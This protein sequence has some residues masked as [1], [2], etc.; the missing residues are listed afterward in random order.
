MTDLV[1]ISS[2]AITAYQRALATVSNNIANVAT[3]GYS[4]QDV[5]LIASKSVSLSGVSLGSGVSVQ[6]IQRQ[7]DAFIES[8]LRNSTSDLATQ[9]PMVDYTNRVINIMGNENMGLSSALDRFFATAR[10]L[11]ADPASSILR[12]T[13]LS[14]TQSLASRMNDLGSQINILQDES[15]DAVEA[16]VTEMNSLATQ[17]AT[18]NTQISKT[19][20][21]TSQ[22]PELLDQRDLLLRKLSEFATINTKF[23][24]SGMVDVSLGPSVTK[25]LL[26]KGTKAILIGA[27]FN[28]ASTEKVSL[29][30]D[31]YG[32]PTPL[33]GISS[34]KLAGL[35]SFREQVLSSTSSA[36]DTMANTLITAINEIHSTG[37]DAYGNP[38]G[39][40][41]SIDPTATTLSMGVRVAI[42]D[43][44]KV[45]A[46][47]QF[48]VIENP[49]NT[50][51]VDATISYE[52]PTY[53]SPALLENIFVNNDHPSAG[54]P[55]SVA[56]SL[57]FKS[58]ATV[59][60][61][62]QDVSIFLNDADPGQDIQI[63]TRDGRQILGKE[64]TNSQQSILINTTNGFE[65]GATFSA[66][67]LNKEPALSY[68]NM[69]IFYG[70]MALI[71][72]SPIFDE[73]GLISS[74]TPYPAALVG[75]S[76]KPGEG[77]IA[78]DSFVLN[79][80][81]LGLLTPASGTLQ[82]SD[83]AS[84]INTEAGST[85]A[86]TV[87]ISD[88]S[89]LASNQLK[90]ATEQVTLS[91]PLTINGVA[92]VSPFTSFNDLAEK[93]TI[94]VSGLSAKITND[95]N[96]LISNSTGL[97]IVIANS[98]NPLGLAAGTYS[99]QVTLSRA[100]AINQDTPIEISIGANGTASDLAKIG[101]R[102]GA[103]I[104]GATADD[105]LV[106]VTGTGSSTVSAAYQ[107]EPIDMMQSM[108]TQPMQVVFT[109]QTQYSITD[110]AT[111]TVLAQRE[112]DTTQR[113]LVISYRGL[114]LNLSAPP[115]SGDSFLL[116]GN[117]DGTG[118]NENMMLIAG[119]ES[120]A[121]AGNNKTIATTYLDQV[122][123][124]ANISRQA[125]IA[126]EALAVVHDQA[127][128]AR[129]QIAGVSLDQEAADLIRYQQ[130][131][132][133]AAKAMQ[134]AT[135]LFDTIIQMH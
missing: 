113:E 16:T 133:A 35:L 52:S 29:V 92:L 96:L 85:A 12:S 127:V 8:N 11:S 88:V 59:Q 103:Y 132:Q 49:N 115:Q 119:L 31:P 125:S 53:T 83:I 71:R 69:D 3:E 24:T 90:I 80:V 40:L 5:S 117:R 91:R 65:D 87:D 18:V 39:A 28:A 64:L 100:L 70:A 109:S 38:G 75:S 57:G 55:V 47:A 130:A 20:L 86:G 7:Y 32:Q 122:N 93:I 51:G 26:V 72:Q 95:G 116:D 110:V 112:F 13:F 135:Q 43:P 66:T 34:G 60:A 62:L 81:S 79:G 107:G 9:Q 131:Y 98:I 123:N 68:K 17:L 30:L 25:D 23:S 67:Y 19:R 37:I 104:S 94:N 126:A 114:Q 58:V 97:D 76:I 99:G 2:S 1:G 128:Q 10:D 106:F 15:R 27:N 45:S 134:T 54:V 129:D 120:K 46:A 42:T 56:N 21:L 4:H 44:L 82:A 63:L 48:R 89:A 36:L 102:T 101:L 84:W 33:A 61:G 124:I 74:Y 6:Y 78:A 108:R 77:A 121:I 41:F 14:D 73:K 105:L 50:G 22:P 111:G 118:N